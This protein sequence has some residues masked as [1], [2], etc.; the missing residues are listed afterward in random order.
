MNTFLEL[1]K[2]NL[3]PPP[4]PEQLDAH[5][6]E[7]AAMSGLGVW[8]PGDAIPESGRRLLVGVALYSA[9]ELRVLDVAAEVARR[10]NSAVRLE[11][12]NTAACRGQEDVNEYIPELAPVYQTPFVGLWQDGL[13]IEK[14][15]GYAGRKLIA[16]VLDV[17]PAIFT[18][19]PSA[20]EA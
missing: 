7:R 20:A 8:K 19:R 14:A 1:H 9:D 3:E 17:D 6:R 12:F 5:F 10:P 11:V 15:S 4:A 13:L 18:A 16:R 2:L